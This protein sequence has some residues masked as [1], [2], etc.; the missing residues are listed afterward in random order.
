MP[1][2]IPPEQGEPFL[3]D[4]LQFL[5]ATASGLASHPF[6]LQASAAGVQVAEWRILACLTDR[7]GQ[8]ITELARLAQMEQSRLTRVVERMEK[9]GYLIRV[10]Q[11]EDRRK[12]HV[13][14][15][16]LGRSVAR[17]LVKRAKTHEAEF[18]AANLTAAEG[19]RL[20]ALL[21]KLIGKA[22]RGD[23]TAVRRA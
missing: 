13:W 5:L 19:D 18:L 23:V 21:C 7:D 15:A 12:V 14:L 10:R 8:T 6:H 20:K 9:R 17:D 2:P 3:D 22:S 16:D 11:D 4:Y 1:H